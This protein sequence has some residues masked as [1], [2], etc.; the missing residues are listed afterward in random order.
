VLREKHDHDRRDEGGGWGIA[1]LGTAR[2]MTVSRVVTRLGGRDGHVLGR[3]ALLDDTRV[4]SA[5]AEHR[6]R[7]RRSASRRVGSSL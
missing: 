4:L 1:Q 7:R 5:I 3:A 2:S 6:D